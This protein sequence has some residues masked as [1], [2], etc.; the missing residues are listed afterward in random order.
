MSIKIPQKSYYNV[1]SVLRQN[2]RSLTVLLLLNVT[3]L[4]KILLYFLLQGQRIKN[5]PEPFPTLCFV[6][7]SYWESNP[8]PWVFLNH[9][10]GWFAKGNIFVTKTNCCLTWRKKIKFSIRLK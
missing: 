9:K 3:V 10:A 8:G 7:Q 1:Y 4:I 6:L 5:L 2:S